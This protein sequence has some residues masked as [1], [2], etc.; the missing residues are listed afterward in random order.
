MLEDKHDNL[1]HAD[2]NGIT[3]AGDTFENGYFPNKAVDND[4]L[5]EDVDDIKSISETEGQLPFAPEELLKTGIEPE[6]EHEE[7]HDAGDE[8]NAEEEASLGE[9]TAVETAVY[10]TTE[11]SETIGGVAEETTGEAVTADESEEWETLAETPLA[12]TSVEEIPADAEAVIADAAEESPVEVHHE[13]EDHAEEVADYSSFS[14]E[15]LTDELQK[16]VVA[17]KINSVK[18]SVEEVKREF[19]S[20]YSDFIEEKKEAFAAE[21]NGDTTD[22]EYNFPLKA[23]FDGLYNQYRDKKNAHFKKVQTDQKGNLEARLAIVEELKTLADGADNFKDAVKQV[24]DLRERWKNAGPIPRD[25]YNH[26]FNN[27]HFHIERF[28]DHLHLDREARDLDFKHNLE[29]KQKIVERVKELVEDAD[30]NKA[31][32]ELQALHKIWKEEIGPVSREHREEIWKQLSD[33]TRQLHDKR[34][35][36]FARSREVETENL[37]TKQEIIAQIDA[38]SAEKVASHG[39]W[40]GQIDKIEALRDKFFKT[41]KVPQE[42]NEATWAAFKA[43]VRNFN[44]VKNSFYKDIK[45]D[46]QHNLNLKL[47]LVAKANELKDSEDFVAT[48]QVM[49]QIQDEWKTVGHVPR[50]YSDVVWK[51][52][53]AACN[54]YFNRLHEQRNAA[55]SEEVE[56][57][58]KKKEYLDSLKDFE[59]TGDHKTD[60]DTIKQHIENWKGFGR[61]PQARR[62]IEGKF[63]KILDALFDKLSLSKKE[64]DMVKFSNRLGQLSES[65]D[66]RKLENEQIFI[67]RKIDEVQAEIFQLE[68]NIQFISNAKPD[69]PFVK[70][71]YKSI[72]RHKEEL[73]TWKEKLKQIRT[74]NQ[75][76]KE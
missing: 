63:N 13:E 61:V 42:V 51:D 68:N 67:M 45:R 62:H 5:P 64:T 37:K 44:T 65:D 19:Y 29:Q 60:L 52:F 57:F 46:Q 48:T 53:K 41:G 18:N 72:D 56:A 34:E 76:T 31:F 17:D 14:I 30:V 3:G 9:T 1:Q 54:H 55:D 7:L 21:N 2:G 35:G 22:F 26:V 50:K 27:F 47:A 59:L 10:E 40:Q 20:K 73:K 69:N 8:V 11:E 38:V 33:L 36:L 58:E 49:K 25:K 39:S 70:E 16:L 24:N 15:A 75:G 4:E 71:V 28:Y 32:R 74:L 23:T 66:S 12:P 43:A 6:N